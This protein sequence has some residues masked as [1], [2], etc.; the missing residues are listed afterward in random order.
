MLQAALF[1]VESFD[2]R[3]PTHQ[4]LKS[5]GRLGLISDR[6]VG[7]CLA[8]V[9]RLLDAIS[10]AEDDLLAAQHATFDPFL[11]DRTDLAA[12]V[13]YGYPQVDSLIGAPVGMDHTDLMI[14][15]QFRGVVALRIHILDKLLRTYAQLR[16]HLTSGC[17]DP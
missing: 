13:P 11:V 9:D 5:T 15:R 2:A 12:V 17:F 8:E 16:V 14:D 3:L 10:D 6:V 7:S 1:N 4:D